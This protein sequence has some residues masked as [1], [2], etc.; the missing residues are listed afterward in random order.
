MGAVL[1]GVEVFGSADDVPATLA[2]EGA[3]LLA[4]GDDLDGLAC[5]LMLF[6]LRQ[7][8]LVEHAVEVAA[9]PA[10]GADRHH[11]HHGVVCRLRKERMLEFLT[12]S[13]HHAP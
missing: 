7:R 10:V 9:E 11:V 2:Q 4:V 12:H 5:S 3:R 1:G 13:T 8:C 6:A